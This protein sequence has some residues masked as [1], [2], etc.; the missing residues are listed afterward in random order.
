MLMVLE[1]AGSLRSVLHGFDTTLDIQ[2]AIDHE[3]LSFTSKESSFATADQYEQMNAGGAVI[4]LNC[5]RVA[6]QDVSEMSLGNKSRKE[7]VKEWNFQVSLLQDGID[8]EKQYQEEMEELE[9]KYHDQHQKAFDL[10]YIDV[11]KSVD[12]YCSILHNN[13]ERYIENPEDY[14]APYTAIVTSSMMGKSRLM[15]QIAL[16]IP[17]VYISLRS[18]HDGEVRIV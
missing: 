12:S 4:L 3:T 5:H 11:S 8:E 10:E 6:S 14:M 7:W 18:Y 17:A 2:T 13:M 15:K 16:K 9:N 1:N